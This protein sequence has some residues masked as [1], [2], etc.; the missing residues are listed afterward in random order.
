MNY[1]L[2]AR[3]QCTLFSITSECFTVE[4]HVQYQSSVTVRIPTLLL[5][6]RIRYAEIHK[7]NVL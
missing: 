4:Q 5:P 7:I 1:T 3:I 6:I 2:K